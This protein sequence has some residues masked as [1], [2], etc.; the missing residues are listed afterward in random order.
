MALS[1]DILK[2]SGV[3]SNY[4][5]ISKVAINYRLKQCIVTIETYLSEDYRNKAKQANKV[6]DDIKILKERA[7][8]VKDKSIATSLNTKAINLQKNNASLLSDIYYISRD[9]ISID[10]IPEDL[11]LSGFYTELKKIEEFKEA[12]DV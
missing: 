6:K 7:K 2:D 4:H 9:D 3:S 12:L 11:T 5:R 10:H 8:N 1:V